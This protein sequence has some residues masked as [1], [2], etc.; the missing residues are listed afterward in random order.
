MKKIITLSLF[1]YLSIGISFSQ[2]VKELD[3]N[4]VN[5]DLNEEEY[6]K[7]KLFFRYGNLFPVINVTI[8]PNSKV[9]ATLDTRGYIVIWDV[10]SRKQTMSIRGIGISR[11]L[12]TPDGKYLIGA[13]H[14]SKELYYWDYMAM[15][16]VPNNTLLLHWQKP[17]E[18]H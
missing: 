10:N 16:I 14:N 11:I 5:T 8:S 2:E 3:Y 15:R 4:F 6:N 7:V 12:F 13:G 1:L 18:L 17:A 9:L